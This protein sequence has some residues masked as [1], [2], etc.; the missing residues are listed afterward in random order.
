MESP[1]PRD[2]EAGKKLADALP[3]MGDLE[4]TRLIIELSV[5]EEFDPWAMGRGRQAD[6]LTALAKRF[7]VDAVKIRA[8]IENAQKEAEGGGTRR[9][10]EKKWPRRPLRQRG[11]PKAAKK[12]PARTKTS[13]K[14]KRPRIKPLRPRQRKPPPSRPGK[15]KERWRPLFPVNIADH[16][17]APEYEPRLVVSVRFE[18]SCWGSRF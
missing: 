9:E 18:D 16:R 10:V 15:S 5:I 13:P 12:A 4:F 17:R 3:K 14:R 7:K 6:K 8:D 11:N 2:Y 1:V